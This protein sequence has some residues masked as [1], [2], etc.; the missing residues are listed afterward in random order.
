MGHR[1][2]PC[3]SRGTVSGDGLE[4]IGKDWVDNEFKPND[5]LKKLE[6]NYKNLGLTRTVYKKGGITITTYEHKKEDGS[7]ALK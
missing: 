6:R 3:A 2:K 4:Q 1:T 7:N 5:L